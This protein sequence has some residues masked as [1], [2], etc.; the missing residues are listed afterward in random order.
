MS[1]NLDLAVLISGRGSNL[2]AM[3]EAIQQGVL[4]ARIRA[5]ISDRMDAAGLDHARRAGLDTRIAERRRHP[6]R[7][8]FEQALTDIIDPLGFDYL[9]LA[10][11]MRVLDPATVERYTGR[12][13]NIHPSLLPNLPGLDTHRRALEAGRAEH[14]ASVH[15]VTPEVDAGPV[16]SRARVNVEPGE[17]PDRLA[18]RVLAREH[19][20]LPA[21]LAL[22]AQQH[23]ELR[24]EQVHING[25]PL[26]A[27]LDLDR[28]LSGGLGVNSSG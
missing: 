14:G 22:L 24:D 10:G 13:I 18:G 26:P 21:T 23:V 19:R 5:V 7:T 15:F 1:R 25:R 8:A 3:I 6:D 2:A 20:L 12:M 28:D 27:P 16:I 9:V 17:D 4:P 11:F